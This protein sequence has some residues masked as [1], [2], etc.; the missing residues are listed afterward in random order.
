[1][2]SNV[3]EFLIHGPSIWFLLIL[4]GL[5][6]HWAVLRIAGRTKLAWSLLWLGPLIAL[7]FTQYGIS[8][9]ASY[10]GQ[11][12]SDSQA[13][14]RRAIRLTLSPTVMA[15]GNIALLVWL[16]SLFERDSD[17]ATEHVSGEGD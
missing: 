7:A 15:I 17:G 2:T 13:A 14:F 8:E 16:D 12:D 11:V 1:M 5:N 10:A 9:A 4:L 6:V 3:F